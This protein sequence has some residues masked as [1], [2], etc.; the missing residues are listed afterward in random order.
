MLSDA[1]SSPLFEHRVFLP[2]SKRAIS[3]KMYMLMPQL[4]PDGPHRSDSVSL[5]R[6][7][8]RR[9]SVRPTV[10]MR[11]LWATLATHSSRR[12]NDPERRLGLAAHLGCSGRSRSAD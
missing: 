11:K 10:R 7:A 9:D 4:A 8:I 12:S 1:L 3:T 6:A 2:P 5:L